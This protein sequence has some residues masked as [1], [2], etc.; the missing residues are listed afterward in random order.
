[1]VFAHRLQGLILLFEFVSYAVSQFVHLAFESI[2]NASALGSILLDFVIKEILNIGSCSL[3]GLGRKQQSHGSSKD[4]TSED[5]S[6]TFN[7]F[8][9][10][11]A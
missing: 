5:S 8:H 3:A 1:L 11:Q 6:H 10:F 4:S 9:C 2:G 7:T